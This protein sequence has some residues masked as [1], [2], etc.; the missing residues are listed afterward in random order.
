A[1]APAIGGFAD[2]IV[3][4][5]RGI[6]LL[7]EHLLIGP[8]IARKQQPHRLVAIHHLDFDRGRTDDV[9]GIPIA[10]A[11]AGARLDPG[12]IGA[13]LAVLEGL[14]GI[15]LGIERLDR[16]IAAPAALA[17]LAFGLALLNPGAVGQHVFEQAGRWFGHPGWA[18]PA[19]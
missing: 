3:K 16:L 13:G 4:A 1:L 6:G 19:L 9:A 10:G 7:V 17:G 2:D 5:G 11:H 8:D 18:A 15:G 14:V 12:F